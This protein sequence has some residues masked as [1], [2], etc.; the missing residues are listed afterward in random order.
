MGMTISEKILASHAG[1]DKVVP[2]QLIMA[3]LDLVMGT[4]VTVPLSVSVFNEIGAFKVF[5]SSK[6]ALVNDH[7][8]PAKDVSA[9]ELSKT[10][11]EFAN[12]AKQKLEN[13][14]NN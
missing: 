1:L 8:V 10:M 13:K 3:K 9:A 14:L 6:I 7:F 11:K 12:K 4:D 2:D 5:D